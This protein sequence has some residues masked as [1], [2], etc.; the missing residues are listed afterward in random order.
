MLSLIA[1]A[2][3]EDSHSFVLSR[4]A[5]CDANNKCDKSLN[6]RPQIKLSNC[7]LCGAKI[8]IKFTVYPY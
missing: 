2:V 7:Y 6:L 5:E 3:L 1:M 4:N 8:L